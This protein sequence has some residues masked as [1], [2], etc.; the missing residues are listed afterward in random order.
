MT[1]FHF[2][3]IS[4]NWNVI[5]D[6][7]AHFIEKHARQLLWCSKL[8]STPLRPTLA[9]PYDEI[10]LLTNF[11]ELK[12]NYRLRGPVG[13]EEWM[14]TFAMFRVISSSFNPYHSK[15][16]R[17]VSL[18]TNL[19]KFKFYHRFGFPF[20]R[21]E[22]TPTFTTFRAILTPFMPNPNKTAQHSFTFDQFLW[23]DVWS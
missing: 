7:D 15:T 22:C 19:L 23:I 13:K 17:Q 14:P 16:G 2:W 21:R 3:T 20:D 6:L 5:I 1:T 10:S 12:F 4:W 18:L 9:K 11:S 8:F